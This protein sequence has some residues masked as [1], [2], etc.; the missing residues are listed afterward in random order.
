MSSYLFPPPSVTSMSIVGSNERFP[1]RRVY[2]IGKN[3]EDHVREMGGS[4]ETEPP[5][6]F[7]KPTDSVV[8]CASN[9]NSNSNSNNDGGSSESESE[10]EVKIPLPIHSKNVHWES[11][12]VAVLSQGGRNIE[13]SQ[14]M[15]CIYGFA[16]GIDLTARDCQEHF[17]K[18]GRP[19]EVSKSFDFSAPIGAILPKS[20]FGAISDQRLKLL[21]NGEV[22]QNITLDKMITDIPNQIA[23][24]SRLFC[25]YP[26]DII[27][28]GTPSGVGQMHPGDKIEVSCCGKGG[29]GGGGGGEVNLECK[30][31]AGPYLD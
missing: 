16:V 27:F 7:M 24:L 30:F 8:D 31:T 22:K 17:K 13:P 2:C 26:G 6:W 28:T 23:M 29:S 5:L 14:A 12:L 1:V 19:W 9:S 21:V 18:K 20:Q 25:L 10:V 11:E 4:V 3:Y 15:D